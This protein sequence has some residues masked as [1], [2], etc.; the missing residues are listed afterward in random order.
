VFPDLCLKCGA[1]RSI[2]RRSKKYTYS[3]VSPLELLRATSP[4]LELFA[5]PLQKYKVLIALP[6]CHACDARHRATFRTMALIWAVPAACLATAVVGGYLGR[7]DEFIGIVG[8]LTI[9]A[10][11]IA[12]MVH[13][14]YGSRR[15]LPGVV[16]IDDKTVTLAS[17]G[18]AAVEQLIESRE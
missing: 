3:P 11:L 16:R 14:A 7:G 13:L 12:A 1:R 6:V 4:L 2:V 5:P 8:G 9:G 10:F 17:L 15:M 18:P